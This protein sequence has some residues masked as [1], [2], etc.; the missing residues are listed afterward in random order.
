MY[1]PDSTAHV[2]CDCIKSISRV[3]EHAEFGGDVVFGGINIREEVRLEIGE[4]GAPVSVRILIRNALR[5]VWYCRHGVSLQKINSLVER[6]HGRI[7]TERKIRSVTT[8]AG[9]FF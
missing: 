2:R 4:S 1:A 6:K 9:N 7:P 5:L 8:E 3:V